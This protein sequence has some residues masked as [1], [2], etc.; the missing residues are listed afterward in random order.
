MESLTLT[1]WT[2]QR[3]KKSGFHSVKVD[4]LDRRKTLD[5]AIETCNELNGRLPRYNNQ[6]DFDKIGSLQVKT[7]VVRVWVRSIFTKRYEIVFQGSYI[8]GTLTGE[9]EHDGT[10]EWY[11]YYDGDKIDIFN[12]QTTPTEQVIRVFGEIS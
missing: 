11:D 8:D 1:S 2:R 7:E 3:W 12:W 6:E 10:G 9:I 4:F 5:K